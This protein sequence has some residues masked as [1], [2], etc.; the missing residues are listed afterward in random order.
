[1]KKTLTIFLSA[2]LLLSACGTTDSMIVEP[3]ISEEKQEEYR[4]LIE[5]SETKL[6][7]DLE[8]QDLIE[9]YFDLAL[10]H[11]RLGQYGTAIEYYN[12]VLEINPQSY[13][14]LNN[15]A[16]L[17][18]ELEMYPEALSYLDD[19]HSYYKD[20]ETYNQSI[21]KDSIRVLVKDKNF[22]QAK[23]VLEEYAVNYTT[24]ETQGFISN[25]FEF[26]SRS[27]AA[28]EAESQ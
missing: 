27:R 8:E 10:G 7:G 3:K 23:M 11:D 25:Q 28:H 1:M 16:S 24:P 22:D 15:A 19:L 5:E 14:A 12:K 13:P 17:Y 26:I 18:E 2:T 4:E 21:V 9:V 6:N 20:E